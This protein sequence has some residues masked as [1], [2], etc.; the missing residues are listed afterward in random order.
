MA[1]TAS[2][3]SS[4]VGV[5]KK[6]IFSSSLS[7]LFSLGLC[8]GSLFSDISLLS[9]SLQV[10]PKVPAG[11][12]TAAARTRWAAESSSSEDERRVVKSAKDRRWEGMREII[13]QIGNHEK[14]CDYA[15]ISKGKLPHVY[16]RGFLLGETKLM[17]LER[18]GTSLSLPRRL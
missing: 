7:V 18:N 15:E 12:P 10:L 3:F 17:R 9:A 1:V 2:P 8:G 6:S 14:I 13:R 16:G 4:Y 5:E 11:G